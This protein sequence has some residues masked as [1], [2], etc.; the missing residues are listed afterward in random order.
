M[1][2]TLHTI[3]WSLQF[4]CFW[5]NLVAFGVKKQR[6]SGIP[7]TNFICEL[8]EYK[9]N[10][11]PAISS[12]HA[13]LSA[14]YFELIICIALLRSVQKRT[15]LNITTVKLHSACRN[16]YETI[17]FQRCSLLVSFKVKRRGTEPCKLIRAWNFHMSRL[18]HS[19][20]SFMLCEATSGGRKNSDKAFAKK[21]MHK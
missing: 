4:S 3:V 10:Q 5:T 14:Y 7:P 2:Y 11:D 16:Q 6:K 9:K 8:N 19:L 17:R 15:I 12:R 1:Y 18:F 21:N 13:V 20:V